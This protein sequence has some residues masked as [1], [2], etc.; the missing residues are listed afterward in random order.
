MNIKVNKN[1]SSKVKEF[2]E[3]QWKIADME[4]YGK[5]ADWK[6]FQY[7]LSVAEGENIVGVLKF[8]GSGG[9]VHITELIVSS[10][11]QG[12]GIGK[13]LMVKMEKMAKNLG[14]H[15]LYLHTGKGWKAVE[16][17]KSMGFK[18]T[19][20]LPDDRFHRITL[21]MTKII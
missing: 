2:T 13:E 20:E 18:K 12:K 14:C 9:V 16:F 4:H 11:N 8:R 21:E 1:N 5:I 17:Y 15:K 7:V 10:T 19:R 6:P 3:E